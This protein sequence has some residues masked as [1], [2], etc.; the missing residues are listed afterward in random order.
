[1]R[2]DIKNDETIHL[3]EQVVFVGR[4]SD[5]TKLPDWFEEAGAGKAAF[6][7]RASEKWEFFFGEFTRYNAHPE[8]AMMGP[9]LEVPERSQ[10]L[11]LLFSTNEKNHLYELTELSIVM[12]VI[13]AG[14]GKLVLVDGYPEDIIESYAWAIT[15]ALLVKRE[16]SPRDPDEDK[17]DRFYIPRVFIGPLGDRAVT[18]AT[19]SSADELERIKGMVRAGDSTHIVDL[20][21]PKWKETKFPE[22]TA[23]F[24]KK[25]RLVNTIQ[26]LYEQRQAG[27]FGGGPGGAVPVGG[28]GLLVQ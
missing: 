2:D 22:L 21:N 15:R 13:A 4:L 18:Y 28:G 16:G 17:G 11:K 10:W 8:R 23:Y 14:Y 26:R 20:S 7:K 12:S 19:A 27:I 6:E 24:E 1:M 9:E 25:E 3:G 5:I